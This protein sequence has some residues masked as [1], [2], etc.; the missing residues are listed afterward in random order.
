MLPHYDTNIQDMYTAWRIDIRRVWLLP[1][2]THN[3]MFA[4]VARVMK[5]ELWFAKRCIKFIKMALIFKNNTV[6]AISNMG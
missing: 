6:C 5:L 4:H 1:R 2:R 3:N